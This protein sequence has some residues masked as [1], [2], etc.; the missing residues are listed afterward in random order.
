MTPEAIM[1]ELLVDASAYVAIETQIR[2]LETTNSERSQDGMVSTVISTL[3]GEMDSPQRE[4]RL[5]YFYYFKNSYDTSISM[6]PKRPLT[7]ESK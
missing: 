2:R 7:E 6:S 1:A 3:K 5:K 4:G